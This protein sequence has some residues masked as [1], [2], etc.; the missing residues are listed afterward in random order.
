MPFSFKP[1]VQP[2]QSGA[3]TGMAPVS[4]YSSSSGMTTS[5][6]PRPDAE[7]TSLFHTLLYLILG[8]TIVVAVA[9]IAYQFIL[10]SQIEG[11]QQQIAM[12]EQQIGVLP[13]DNM[14]KLS[15]RMKLITQL[16]NE[17]PS[18]NVAFKIL[19]DSIEHQ[20][21]YTRMELRYSEQAKSYML[22][23][24]G[25]APNYRAV[26]QQMDTYKRD[27]Y[28]S[29]LSNVEIEN[30]QPDPSGKVRFLVKM[31]IRIAG[32]L[33]ETVNLTN[34][35]APKITTPGPATTTTPG[36]TGTS[37]QPVV[38]TGTQPV[39]IGPARP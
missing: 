2:E 7:N 28:K 9:L 25:V 11:K 10:T 17:H 32:L 30:L 23:L 8:A 13:L 5:L 37:T 29:F 22:Q 19:E 4:T 38:A 26:A 39:S 34:G 12:Y 33:P 31:N 3:Q 14:R 16:V 36:V 24:A 1:D 18:V 27:A 21:T 6:P 15:Q 35:A 20:V